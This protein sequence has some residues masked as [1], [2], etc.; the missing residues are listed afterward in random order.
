MKRHVEDEEM[1]L[2]NYSDGLSDAPLPE[3]VEFFSASGKTAC[4]M[5]IRPNF[6]YHLVDFAEDGTVRRFG[7]ATIPKP[8]SMA[9]S[10]FSD[11]ASS[12]SCGRARS[13]WSSRSS[14]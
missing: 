4:F 6:S 14:A 5:A 12:S 9:A 7:P 2:A 11:H 3:M 8:G 10:L 13:W 1:F